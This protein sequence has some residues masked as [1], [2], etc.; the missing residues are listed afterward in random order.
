MSSSIQVPNTFTLTGDSLQRAR[1]ALKIVEDQI[2]AAQGGGYG[3]H[4]VDALSLAEEAVGTQ[5]VLL[6]DALED[7]RAEAEECDN[8][9]WF[10]RYRAA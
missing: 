2:R 1:Q 8:A 5:T 6:K 9:A 4:V 10:P 7:D 3:R